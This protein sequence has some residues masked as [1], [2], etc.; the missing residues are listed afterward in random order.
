MRDKATRDPQKRHLETSVELTAQS[1]ARGTIE[2]EAFVGSISPEFPEGGLI[3]AC[4]LFGKAS[5]M[6]MQPLVKDVNSR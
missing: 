2:E 3:F 6:S 4:H 5:D 1:L